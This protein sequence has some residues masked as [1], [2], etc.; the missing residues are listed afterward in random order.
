LLLECA[1]QTEYSSAEELLHFKGGVKIINEIREQHPELFDEEL[2]NR[3]IEESKNAVDYESKI[4]DWILGDYDMKLSKNE[5]LSAELMK[6]FIK[7]RLNESLV[8]IGYKPA[9]D[10]FDVEEVKIKTT[11][12]DEQVIGGRYSDFFNLKPTEYVKNSQSFDVDS[13]FDN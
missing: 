3:V 2:E 1:K 4:I 11:W 8:E 13:I 10:D 9:Y 12:F 5:T 6:A 7:N